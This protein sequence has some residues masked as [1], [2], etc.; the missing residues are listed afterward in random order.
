MPTRES[1]PTTVTRLTPPGEGGISVVRLRGPAAAAILGRCFRP[2][3]RA[4]DGADPRHIRYGTIADET[5]GTLD[6]VIVRPGEA[7]ADINC[8]G[9]ALVT[10]RVT[11][12]LVRLGAVETDEPRA[13]TLDAIQVEAW[14]A[15]LNAPTGLA[16]AVLL[17]QYNGALTDRLHEL[18]GRL[19]AGDDVAADLADLQGTAVFGRRLVTPPR[20]VIAGRPNVGKSSLLNAVVGGDRALV[21]HVPGTTRDYLDVTV[22]FRGLPVTL[23]DTAGLRE[24]HDAI[25]RAGVGRALEQVEAADLVALVFDASCP[26]CD[27]D[28]EWARALSADATRPVAAVLN[29]IDLPQR[30]PTAEVTALV[31][32]A[33][34]SVSAQTGEGVETLGARIAESLFGAPP[35]RGAAV[36]FT[37]RQDD[38]LRRAGALLSD[39]PSGAS[40]LLRAIVRP[41]SRS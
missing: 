39:D 21:H 14:R 40:A 3:G 20:V 37:D 36:V 4:G 6:E 41:H 29:K 35:A 26:L 31:G 15:L 27:A 19:D 9:G 28:R 33:P 17:D 22:S 18:A 16:A 12:L 8:H 30:I 2:I 5:G 34:L 11:G 10:R 13:G 23:H 32:S 24:T 25:E 1:S 38:L 7:C